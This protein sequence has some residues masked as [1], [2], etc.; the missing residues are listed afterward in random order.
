M[1]NKRQTSRNSSKTTETKHQHECA[2]SDWDYRERRLET[3]LN[4][5]KPYLYIYNLLIHP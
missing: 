2:D 3:P 5:C 1:E 4:T